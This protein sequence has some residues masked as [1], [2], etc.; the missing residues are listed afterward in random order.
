[1][2]QLAP[3]QYKVIIGLILSFSFS[4]REGT[5][6]ITFA[7]KYSNNAKIGFKQSADRASY[8]LFVFNILSHYC[9]TS[10]QLTTGI[11][12]N[13]RYYGLQFFTRS[14]PYI[15][16][17]YSLFYPKGVKTIPHNI[18]ELLTPIGLAHSVIGDGVA[19]QAGLV[20]CTDSYSIGDTVSLINVLIIKY[21]LD[22]R[23]RLDMKNK[24]RIYIR[25]KSMAALIDII[26]SYML[27]N[28]L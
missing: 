20:L 11:R 12:S 16:E 18:Y 13:K 25:Q 27:F 22:C 14:M 8:V 26:S 19:K 6:W 2:R 17:L 9:G 24:D 23:L 5:G 28:M 10:S 7:S 3:Y 4:S 21:R 1:M 15:I